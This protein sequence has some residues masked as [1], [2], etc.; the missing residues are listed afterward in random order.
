MAE[1]DAVLSFLEQALAGVQPVVTEAGGLG[2]AT[3]VRRYREGF[4][5]G[6]ELLGELRDLGYSAARSDRYQRQAQLEYETDFLADLITALRGAFQK[7]LV[8]EGEL[9]A[10]LGELGLRQERVDAL[11]Q[12]ELARFARRPAA[13]VA[14]PRYQTAA[15]RARI[16]AVRTAFQAGQI[17]DAELREAF[18]GE[19][20]PDELAAAEVALDLARFAARR[21]APPERPVAVW[22]SA[23][24]RRKITANT[25]LFIGGKIDEATLRARLA[26][27]AMPAGV[28]EAEID[29]ALARRAVKPIPAPPTPPRE[30]LE[31]ETPAGRTRVL[32]LRMLY[33]EQLIGDDDLLAELRALEL[34]ESL[35]SAILEQEQVRLAAAGVARA[36]LA[37]PLYQTPAGKVA[38]ETARL[39]FRRRLSDPAELYGSLLGAG[40]PEELAQA[41]LDYEQTRLA[42][43]VAGS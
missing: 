41:I 31:Y 6:A 27:L 30:L 10:R 28:L 22:E 42:A 40:M 26:E 16:A 5:T 2:A 1:I 7:E 4:T 18:A 39:R 29:L 35:A 11:L 12:I 36:G 8:G 19:E 14:K 13:A 24:G 21:A 25:T 43:P 38:V 34:P 17:G 20:M 37:I 9:R 33:Q 32:T 15:G 3:A 23:E